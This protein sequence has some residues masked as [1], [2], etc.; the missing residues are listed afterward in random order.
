MDE[1]DLIKL[2]A[3]V[4]K[5]SSIEESDQYS[6]AKKSKFMKDNNIKPGTKEWFQL[7]FA[8]PKLTGEDPFGG[9]QC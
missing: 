3:G 8:K 7:W 6:A 5:E 9:K 4:K 2:L 1:L